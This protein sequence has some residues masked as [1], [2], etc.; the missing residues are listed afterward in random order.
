[1]NQT[2]ESQGHHNNYIIHYMHDSKKVKRKG[3]QWTLGEEW[4]VPIKHLQLCVSL[5]EP[6]NTPVS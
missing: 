1:M 6:L 5:P 2:W 3:K 4:P